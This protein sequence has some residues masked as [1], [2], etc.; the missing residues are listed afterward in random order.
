MSLTND[1]ESGPLKCTT[2]P[3]QIVLVAFLLSFDIYG[4]TIRTI[5]NDRRPLIKV[6]GFIYPD[7][8]TY[9]GFSIHLEFERTLR[10]KAY[11]TSGPR[12]DYINF[13]DFFDKNFFIGYELKFYPFYFR[14]KKPYH[15]VFIGGE[16]LYLVQTNANSYS[17]YGPGVGTFV[18]YQHVIKDKFSVAIE[19]AMAYI[20][21]LN[22][23]SPQNSTDA[24]YFY[25]LICLK[26]G[27]KL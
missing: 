9:G 12:L 8:S 18:G 25:F 6:G 4:Q 3:M 21:D 17:R 23:D 24:K 14:T 10:R 15:G 27:I 1:L 11:L 13:E 5:D 20:L 19:P 26:F 2:L 22:G 7:S 16:L